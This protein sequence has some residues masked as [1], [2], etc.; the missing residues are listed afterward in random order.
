M[1][2]GLA[3]HSL[4]LTRAGLFAEVAGLHQGDPSA[5]KVER[6][7]YAAMWDYG[8][9]SLLAERLNTEK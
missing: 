1:R 3:D 5:E 2:V 9:P 6:H 7:Y 4:S 8:A